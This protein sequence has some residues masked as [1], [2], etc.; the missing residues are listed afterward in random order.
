M[1]W[2]P[3]FLISICTL[4][5]F[6]LQCAECNLL[7]TS[8]ISRCV[9]DCQQ[10]ASAHI[11]C[12][13]QNIRCFCLDRTLRT[14]TVLC[15]KKNCGMR[16]FQSQCLKLFIQFQSSNQFRYYRFT[17][18]FVL[19][20]STQYWKSNENYRCCVDSYGRSHSL[21]ADMYKIDTRKLYVS[22]NR[23]YFRLLRLGQFMKCFFDSRLI[24]SS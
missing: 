22:W 13:P 23:R 17:K 8:T 9:N 14:Q 1:L 20:I 18:I 11:N 5:S 6:F 21:A 15:A 10:I 3:K 2:F 4:Q 16:E 19:P 24:K 7:N 12:A